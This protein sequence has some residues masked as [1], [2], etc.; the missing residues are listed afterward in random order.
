MIEFVRH[1]LLLSGVGLDIDNVSYSISDEVGG[2]LNG[3]MLC[4]II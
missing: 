2:Q 1:A 3:T 4:W